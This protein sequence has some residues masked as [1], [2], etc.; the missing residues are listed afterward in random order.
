MTL[1]EKTE[2][3]TFLSEK[4]K[5]EETER[6]QIKESVE[7]LELQE[8]INKIAE[9]QNAMFQFTDDSG[10]ELEELKLEIM[11]YFIEKKITSYE[12]IKAKYKRNKEVSVSKVLDVIGGDIDALVSISNISQKSLK[13]YAKS[14]KDK[15]LKRELMNCVEETNITI[16]YLL[17][18]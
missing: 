15:K 1:Q 17:I 6:K 10:Q 5:K 9:K 18:T 7:Y 3:M 2:R 12:N 11:R 16:S 14:F 4:V 13:E 8:E